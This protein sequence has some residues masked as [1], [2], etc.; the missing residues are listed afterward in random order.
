MGVFIMVTFLLISED[1]D[2]ATYHYFP[3]GRENDGYGIITL[4]KNPPNIEITKLASDDWQ[5][6]VSADEDL[7]LRNAVNELRIE[8]EEPLL[9][10]EEW[11][12]QGVQYVVTFYAD[13]AMS[14]IWKEY[15]HGKVIKEGMAAWY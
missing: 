8:N 2:Y 6:H 15:K 10:E 5:S 14:R 7:K 11:P 1:I 12:S 13:H 4:F 9:T 3:E